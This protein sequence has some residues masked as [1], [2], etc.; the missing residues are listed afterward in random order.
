MPRRKSGRS[1]GGL[2]RPRILLRSTM[3][4]HRT[5]SLLIAISLL[6]VFVSLSGLFLSIPLG[7]RGFVD[8]R[9]LYTAGYMVRTGQGASLY[10]F[11]ESE[12]LQNMLVGRAEGA[13]QFNHLAYESLLYVPFSLLSYRSAYLGFLV[14]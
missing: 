11:A 6:L 7:M 3:S 8:F 10:D 2:E 5:R 12:R 14:F 4:M 13:L 9:H 1:D